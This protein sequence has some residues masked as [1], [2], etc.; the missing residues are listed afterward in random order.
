MKRSLLPITLVAFFV[1]AGVAVLVIKFPISEERILEIKDLIEGPE[2]VVEITTDYEGAKIDPTKLLKGCLGRDCIP[3][4]DDPKFEPMQ[5]AD[6]WLNDEDKVFGLV[7]K[8][9]ERAYPQRILNW[10]EIVNDK[11]AGEPVAVTF[12]PLCGTAV[13]FIRKVNGEGAEFGVSGY[14]VESDLVMYDRHEGNLWQQLTLEAIV[15]PAAR[16]DEE[17]Q[18]VGI[19]TTDWASWKAQ[20]PNTQVL[21]KP[22]ESMK[23]YDR[24]PYGEYEENSEVR[25]GAEHSDKRLHPKDVVY[26]VVVNGQAKAYPLAKLELQTGFEDVIDD[27]PV[28]VQYMEDGTVVVTNRSTGESYHVQR[29]FW[30]GW[31]A[32]NPGTQLY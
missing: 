32:F 2:P 18:W 21:S 27:V 26:G 25:F 4:I 13:A 20:H 9:V 12:C 1:L 28:M 16:R 17:L 14:L 10:H 7:H 30:F 5:K 8:G 23:D 11:V 29:S 22:E 15:G 3:S 31:V 6:E 24:Y 19:T